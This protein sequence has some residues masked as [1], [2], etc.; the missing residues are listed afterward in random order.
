MVTRAR[1]L[2]CDPHHIQARRHIQA[3]LDDVISITDGPQG[4]V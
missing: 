4:H 1:A 3:R 2:G